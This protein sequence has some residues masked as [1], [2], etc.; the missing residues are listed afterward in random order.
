MLHTFPRTNASLTHTNTATKDI[1]GKPMQPELYMF[2]VK[3]TEEAT[4]IEIS[5]ATV[6][7]RC[8]LGQEQNRT[9]SALPGLSTII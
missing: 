1:Q 8:G 5:G 7:K 9:S 3:K 6:T 2:S 4:Q